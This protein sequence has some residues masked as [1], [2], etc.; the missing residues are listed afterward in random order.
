M[1]TPK[2]KRLIIYDD[3]NIYTST[4]KRTRNLSTIA[5][6]GVTY[7]KRWNEKGV[8]EEMMVMTTYLP[9]F[10][11]DND[12]IPPLKTKNVSNGCADDVC[13]YTSTLSPVIQ[14]I[15]KKAGNNFYLLWEMINDLAQS[16]S[17]GEYSL[18]QL[19]V[20]YFL[21]NINEYHFSYLSCVKFLLRH[22]DNIPSPKN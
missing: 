17:G 9:E 14:Q 20:L 18:Q 15:F 7:I 5:G 8:W 11:K 6:N 19:N 13:I 1:A 2:C 12:G 22:M 4:K 16:R 21:R 3:V 10:K